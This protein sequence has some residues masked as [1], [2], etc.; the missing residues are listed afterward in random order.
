MLPRIGIVGLPEQI[1]VLVPILKSVDFQ[2][3]A[4]WCKNPDTRKKLAIMF[5]SSFVPGDFSNLLTRKDVDLVYVATEPG[6]QA[7]VAVK[8]LTSGKHCICQKPPTIN[9][10]EAKKMVGL[11]RYYGKLQSLLESHLRF[12]PAVCKLKSLL[13]EGYCGKVL[14][15]EAHVLMGP[16]IFDEAYSW[17]CEP[18]M[19]GGALNTVGAHIIDLITFLSNQ[20]A[21]KAHATLNTFRPTTSTIHGYRTITSDDYCCFQL[22]CSDGLSATVILNSHVPGQFN[23]HFSVTG[24]QGR[25]VLRGLDLFGSRGG[26]AGEEVILR[27]EQPDLRAFDLKLSSNYPRNYI[28]HFVLGHHEMFKALKKTFLE[29]QQNKAKFLSKPIAGSSKVQHHQPQTISSATFEDGVYIRTVL[30]A[31]HSSNKEGKWLDIPYQIPKLGSSQEHSNPFW[32]SSTQLA[33]AEK[34]SPKFQRPVYV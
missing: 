22:K 3:T 29:G 16:L 32:T 28:I 7:E 20:H 8:A 23:F 31:L 18:S 5:D 24:T 34:S 33:D 26:S 19:G 12:L 11:S 14:M 17:R 21:C 1:N 27:Q 13:S 25:L 10:S 6:K 15:M 30:D 9:Q 2:V 4:L